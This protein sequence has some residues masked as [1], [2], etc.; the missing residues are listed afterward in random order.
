MDSGLGIGSLVVGILGA[1]IGYSSLYFYSSIF[2]F[3]GL[4]VYYFL[5]GKESRSLRE[6][7]NNQAVEVR[8]VN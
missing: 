6:S 8:E 3:A 2:V 5:H 7:A 4:I 1:Q